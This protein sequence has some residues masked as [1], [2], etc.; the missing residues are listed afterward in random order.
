MSERGCARTVKTPVARHHFS[1]QL[2]FPAGQKT[3]KKHTS[4]EWISLECY[5]MC[6]LVAQTPSKSVGEQTQKKVQIEQNKD[7]K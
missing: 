7:G 1:D 2:P 5:D 4:S 3:E 6:T